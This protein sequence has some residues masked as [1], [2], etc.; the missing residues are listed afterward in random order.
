[1]HLDW[2]QGASGRLSAPAPR[3][4][5]YLLS[6]HATGQ[7]WAVDFKAR[8]ARARTLAVVRSA[9]D[10][11]ALAKDDA[12]A[13]TLTWHRRRELADG[14]VYDEAKVPGETYQVQHTRDDG[15]AFVLRCRYASG[16]VT[17]LGRFRTVI[18]A[19]AAAGVRAA[20]T[21]A[22]CAALAPTRGKAAVAENPLSSGEKTGVVLGGIVLA[23]LAIWGIVAANRAPAK[24]PITP[25]S[26]G[27][28]GA[29]PGGDGGHVPPGGGS[30]L[31]PLTGP[32]TGPIPTPSPQP[33]KKQPGGHWL[34]VTALKKGVRYRVSADARGTLHNLGFDL[35]TEHDAIPTGWPPGDLD[36]N[37]WRIEG[38]WNDAGMPIDPTYFA[39]PYNLRVWVW[40]KGLSSTSKQ[41]VGHWTP[42][43]TLV[44]GQMYR[45]SATARAALQS[46]GIT[47]LADHEAAPADWPNTDLDLGRFRVDGTWTLSDTTL[48]AQDLASY[49]GAR[50]FEYR[51]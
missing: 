48:T 23:G 30:N 16:R 18:A 3:G 2:T 27:D 36:P 26:G 39:A 32:L 5:R 9:S 8:G 21:R 7:F 29:N 20:K 11:K 40:E 45:A 41:G 49:G 34:E 28:G 46:L 50:L 15:G 1:M 38:V 42:T 43:T 17:K 22:R 33:P 44:K 14:D 10:A 12:L 4:A 19:K 35:Y 25:V 37:R 6:P 24:A 47:V 13:R 31:P 51:L